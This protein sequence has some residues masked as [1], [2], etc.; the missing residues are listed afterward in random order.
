MCHCPRVPD[1]ATETWT[2]FVRAIYRSRV[3]HLSLG[4]EI[5]Q[6]DLQMG[7]DGN[8]ALVRNVGKSG[9]PPYL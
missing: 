2:S 6:G 1:G 5:V 8:V 3:T 7:A 9:N 4:L